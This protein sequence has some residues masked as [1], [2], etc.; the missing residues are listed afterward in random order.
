MSIIT[1]TDVKTE[2]KVTSETDDA[3]MTLMCTA[4]ESMWDLLTNKTWV[5]AEKVE[6]VEKKTRNTIILKNYPVTSVAYIGIGEAGAIYLKNTNFNGY[7]TVDISTTAIT[8]N[9]NGSE[10]IID[11]AT[12]ATISTAVAQINTIGDGWAAE[13]V[14]GYDTYPSSL[15][16]EVSGQN[17]IDSTQIDLNIPSDFSSTTTLN[18]NTGVVRGDFMGGTVT[19]KY[20]SGY[21]SDTFPL[22]LKQLLVRQASHWYRQATGKNWDYTKI[23][24]QEG[25]TIDFSKVSEY[26][27][28]PDFVKSAKMN[29]KINA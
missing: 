4:V 26:N 19:V 5:S 14:S 9:Y 29:R 27:L 13:V 21:T 18:K 22:F 2:M 20:T 15:L 11:F 6:T 12:Y 7:A 16:L 8:L 17:C 23:D 1:N 3:L 25:G 10:E 28:L 24:K